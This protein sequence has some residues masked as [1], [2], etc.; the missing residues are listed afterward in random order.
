MTLDVNVPE[1]AAVYVNGRLTKSKGA[2]R[3]L[4]GSL[5]K[6]D[7]ATR[8]EV[9]AVIDGDGHTA[10]ETQVVTVKPGSTRKLSFD[11]GLPEPTQTVLIL[12]VPTDAKV[13]IGEREIMGR[14]Q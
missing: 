1:N 5:M 4:S 13:Q 10:E 8:L 14:R 3:V 11:L 7:R 9:R 12:N 2:H 6:R